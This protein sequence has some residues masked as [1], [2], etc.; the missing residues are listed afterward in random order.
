MLNAHGRYVNVSDGGHIE[1]LG[2][3]EL[4]RRRC[5]IIVAVDAESDPTLNCDS[6]ATLVR[7]ALIDLGVTIDIDLAAIRDHEGGVSRSHWAVGRI[8]YGPSPDDT[9]TL[10]YLKSSL[11]GDE[12]E[13]INAFRRRYPV[14]PQQSTADQ[15]FDETRFETY[16]AL[17][18]HVASVALRSGGPLSELLADYIAT[19]AAAFPPAVAPMSVVA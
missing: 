5:K 12:N 6:V 3:Y 17:G 11:T 8:H 14:F 9:G 1:N 7:Y 18:D 10:F 19:P 13:Y 16:R 2:V 15:F 4:L